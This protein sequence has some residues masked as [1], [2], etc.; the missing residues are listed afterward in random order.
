[1]KP[2]KIVV[3]AGLASS[4][5]NF[6]GPLLAAMRRRGHK[7]VACA[8]EEDGSTMASLTEMEV[9]Y[10]SIPMR[11][12]G[13]D[14]VGDFLY[15]V[16]LW[17]ALRKQAPDLVLAYTIKPVVF[18][19]LAARLAGIRRRIAL[20]TGLGYAFMGGASLHQRTARWAAIR[21]Y[22]WALNGVEK[23]FFQNPD[24]HA[25]FIRLGI[26]SADAPVCVINGSGVDLVHFPCAPLASAPTFLMIARL[27]RDKGV[28]EFVQAAEL[29]KAHYP[30]AR[31]VLVGGFDTNPHGIPPA[32][33]ASWTSGGAIEHWGEL[34]DV[35]PALAE[36]SVYVLPS[37]REG[38]P[39][40]TL[41]AMATGRP[42]ITTDAPG[43]R[44][45]V[46]QG[47]NGFLVPVRDPHSLAD[48]M[49][50][51]LESPDLVTRMARHSRQIA[52]EKYDVN[53]VNAVMLKE[54][55]LG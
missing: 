50:R 25:E 14:P 29:V 35:R 38:T 31:F 16:R 1:M 54:M 2:K 9:D 51:L 17:R 41:E 28:I 30:E 43:C 15:L 52:E 22:R 27:L 37:Y 3:V 11:R 23:V 18:G 48:A 24:D 46:I 13:I 34:K 47:K 42:I 6:R 53:K 12:A 26:L 4:L 40:T 21:L 20:I 49:V 36:C 32:Q 7:I 33:V 8:P 45:T 55:G 44:E 39:R 10:F 19:L 5:I